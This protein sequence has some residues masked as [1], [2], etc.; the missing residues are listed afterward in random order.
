MDTDEYLALCRAVDAEPFITINFNA[1]PQLAADWVRYCNR[2]RGYNVKYWEVGDE[3]WGTWAKGH[4]P[5][6]V[7]AKKYLTFVRAM[8][9]VD[10]TIKIA[11]NVPLGPHP[12]QGTTRVLKAAGRHG[13]RNMMIPS[14]PV[15]MCTGASSWIS[16]A[17]SCRSWVPGAAGRSGWSTWGTIR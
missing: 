6:E 13:E 12:E 4:A 15:S 1:S 9:A 14:S 3:Q 11:T 17:R 8:K 10:P 16:G 5:P 2:E 7:Y